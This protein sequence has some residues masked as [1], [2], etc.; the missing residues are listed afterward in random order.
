MPLNLELKELLRKLAEKYETKEFLHGDPSQFMHKVSG[1]FNREATAFTAAALSFGARKQFLPKIAEIVDCASGDVDLWVRS[2][3]YR[4]RFA[5]D[6]K[7]PFYRFFTMSDMR[8]FFDA[9]RSILMRHGSLGELVCK[10]AERS[11][12][13]AVSEICKA[14]AD[15]GGCKAV[16]CNALSSCK[17]LCMFMRWMVRDSSAVDLGLWA[18]FVDK[19][20]L[21]MPLDT[22]VLCQS[23]RLGLRKTKT[24]SMRC[25]VNLTQK[26]KEVFPD[27]PL[28]GDFALFGLGVDLK[29][30][31]LN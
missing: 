1:E 20:S 23:Q 30:A 9:F 29:S 10:R 14:F 3:E 19:T 26:L 17:R 4:S 5:A 22:H 21:A 25:A 28:K 7:A 11:G 13:C 31:P 8:M 12:V 24:S 16:P 27:D 6:D 2:G 18:D 15:V